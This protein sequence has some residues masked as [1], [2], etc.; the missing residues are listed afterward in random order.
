MIEIVVNGEKERLKEETTIKE[1]VA[2][3][4]YQEKSFA[5]AVNGTFVP[6]KEY[7]QKMIKNGD[8]IDILAPMVGG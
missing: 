1:I 2:S 4:G 8:V 6:L 7:E 3:L 5:V